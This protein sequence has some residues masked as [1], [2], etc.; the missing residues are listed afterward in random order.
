MSG[1]GNHRDERRKLREL[2][3]QMDNPVVY[4]LE[5]YL[6]DEAGAFGL[7]RLGVDVMARDIQ[8]RHKSKVSAALLGL[9]SLRDEN[10]QP[11]M[12]YDADTLVGYFP[13]AMLAC[14]PRGLQHVIA[15]ENAAAR[16]PMCE[17]VRQMLRELKPFQDRFA[18][19]ERG[20][21]P[22]YQ[23]VVDAYHEALPEAPLVSAL[24]VAPH[25]AL[26]QTVA[27][28]W[29]KCERS[30]SKARAWMRFAAG[31]TSD[32]TFVH[33]GRAHPVTLALLLQPE[34]RSVLNARR[35]MQQGPP[36][37]PD[38]VSSSI[39]HGGM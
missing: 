37:P 5:P 3:R 19:E 2:L 18:S 8:Q 30:P 38:P 1:I 20:V 29:E 13:G 21:Q 31:Q 39:Q 23:P 24:E 36:E 27:H 25:T 26:G 22:E 11:I 15:R 4:A 14:K 17:P 35:R 9:A 6:R 7:F 28:V 33:E 10:G 34:V 16:L 12:L 32:G